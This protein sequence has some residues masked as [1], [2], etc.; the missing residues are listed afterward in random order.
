M[1]II[2]NILY[3]FANAKDSNLPIADG[4]RRQLV[5]CEPNIG[6]HDV[7]SN[8]YEFI[9]H[10]GFVADNPKLYMFGNDMKIMTILENAIAAN[11]VR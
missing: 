3:S 9:Q 5:K 7:N 4:M 8:A 11:C 6:W 1:T 2:N 10:I